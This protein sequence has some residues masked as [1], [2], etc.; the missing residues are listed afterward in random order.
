M[1]SVASNQ[2][3]SGAGPGSRVG[4]N[5]VE[6]GGRRIVREIKIKIKKNN[7]PEHKASLKNR[8]DAKKPL[9]K[10]KKR[11][12]KGKRVLRHK[13]TFPVKRQEYGEATW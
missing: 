3:A 11:Q 8:K 1:L 9:Y 10:G 2:G 12:S 4:V 6:G 7:S 13:G 5:R